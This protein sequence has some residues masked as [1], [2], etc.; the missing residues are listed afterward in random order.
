MKAHQPAAEGPI[1]KEVQSDHVCE[2]V[3]RVPVAEAGCHKGVPAARPEMIQAGHEVSGHEGWVQLPI[4]PCHN[5]CAHQQPQRCFTVEPAW[6]LPADRPMSV[7]RALPLVHVHRCAAS[8]A[9]GGETP[10]TPHP[11]W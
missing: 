5:I 8:I 7:W 4:D 6:T 3:Q 2:E 11:Y 10:V 1:P 9:F